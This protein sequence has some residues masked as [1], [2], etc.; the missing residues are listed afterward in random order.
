MDQWVSVPRRWGGNGPQP[1]EAPATTVAGDPRLSS[2]SSHHNEGEQNGH[3]LRV[4]LWEAAILQSFP[5]DYPFQGSRTKQFE[6]VGNAVPPL[7]ALAILSALLAP[8]LTQ[9]S[10]TEAAA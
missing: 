8:V 6:Q 3:S 9:Q 7:M 10:R 1:D 5:P 4:E 2:R